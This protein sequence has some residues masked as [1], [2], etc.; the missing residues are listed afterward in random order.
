MTN[1]PINNFTRVQAF[2]WPTSQ[3]TIQSNELSSEHNPLLTSDSGVEQSSENGV[4]LLANHC[5]YTLSYLSAR[6][7]A[8]LAQT[9]NGANVAASNEANQQLFRRN[10]MPNN[11]NIFQVLDHEQNIELFIKHFESI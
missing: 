7:L 11:E 2:G 4:P 3:P 1:T 10:V 9:S 6:N 8:I 5:P